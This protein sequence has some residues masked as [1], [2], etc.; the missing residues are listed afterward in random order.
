MNNP[1]EVTKVH[2]QMKESMHL[3]LSKD[4][5]INVIF[6]IQSTQNYIL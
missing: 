4:D 1:E 3:N 2:Q 5:Q 6:G